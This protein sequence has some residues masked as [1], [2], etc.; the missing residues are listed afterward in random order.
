MEIYF[1]FACFKLS[2]SPIF[3]QVVIQ[4]TISTNY[5]HNIYVILKIINIKFMYTKL[6]RIMREL[7]R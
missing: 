2:W 6:V 5:L 3:I 1:Y 7:P 4:R